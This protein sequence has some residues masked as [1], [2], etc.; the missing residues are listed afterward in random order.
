MKEN[1]QN[2]VKKKPQMYG[3]AAGQHWICVAWTG[4]P[5]GPEGIPQ[6]STQ[7]CERRF[8]ILLENR[9]IK[10]DRYLAI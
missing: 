2:D 3:S 4:K 1:L 8:A 5:S 9:V 7:R 10:G 6:R